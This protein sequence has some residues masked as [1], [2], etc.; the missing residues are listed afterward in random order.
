MGNQPRLIFVGGLSGS[1][2]T[3]LISSLDGRRALTHLIAGRLIADERTRG[4]AA[5]YTRPLLKDG[6]D[7]AY[8]QQLLLAALQREREACGGTILLDGHFV[9]P[10][11]AGLRWS[12]RRSSL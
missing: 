9:V 6:G 8:F 12:R 1:G 5:D 2:K 7:A 4:A 11:E 3:H 10:T